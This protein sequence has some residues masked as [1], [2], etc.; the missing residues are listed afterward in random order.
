MPA[1][2]TLNKHMLQSVLQD[3]ATRAGPRKAGV[4]AAALRCVRSPQAFLLAVG[5]M[6][7]G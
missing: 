5:D 1:P 2:Y 7:N 3:V 6:L 4:H